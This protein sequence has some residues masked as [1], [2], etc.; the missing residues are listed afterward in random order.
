VRFLLLLLCG[1]VLF[2][3]TKQASSP[4][5]GYYTLYFKTEN[6]TIPARLD[7]RDNGWHIINAEEVILLDSVELRADSFF[8]KLPLFDS[9]MKGVWR[10]D[11]LIGQW[12]DHSRVQYSIP[13]AGVKSMTTGCDDRV[14]EL[15]YDIVFSPS[16]SS[17]SRRGIAVLQKSGHLVTGTVLTETGDYRYLQGE[18][19]KDTLWLSAFDGTHL[20]YLIGRVV[21]DSIID[22]VF[23][24][25]KHWKE[26]W[27]AV[28][29]TSNTLRDPFSITS[30]RANTPVRFEVLN[31]TGDSMLFDS[32]TWKNHVSII[33]IM[34]SWCPNCT[35]ESRFL[36]TLFEQHAS[37]GLQ[38]IPVAFE[39]G[40]DITTSC[41]RVDEQF[42]QLG[43]RYPFYY[44]GKAGKDI[45]LETFPF[46]TGVH[47]FPTSIFIDR[48]GI[49]RKVY[50]G[51]YG[52]G[53]GAEYERHTK[54]IEALVDSLL[55]E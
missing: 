31:A 13:F 23:L 15:H 36:K 41:T 28:K 52:P 26:D 4:T 19:M 3:C 54:T 16:D 6:G 42:Q 8:V 47:S 35:D 32:S 38:I 30:I 33:Q 46:L 45:A 24:S 21:G 49:V 18:I 43:L 40:E 50:T 27:A 34:G 17:E 22:G 25:G 11:S 29:S 1:C 14:E 20:F 44:G 7:I 37:K 48:R 5:P 12:T 53:T 55:S 9:S 51:F 39:R 10:N 2:G